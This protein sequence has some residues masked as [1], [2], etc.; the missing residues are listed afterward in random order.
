MSKLPLPTKILYGLGQL[1]ETTPA[2]Y[3]PTYIYLFYAPLHGPVLLSAYTVGVAMLL[4]TLTQAVANPFIGNWSDK[5]TSRLGR[6]R[7]FILTGSIPFGLVFFLIWSPFSHGIILAILLVFYLI[8]WDL[9]YVYVGVPYLALIPELTFESDDR[10]VLTTI[11]SYV[12]IF[13]IILAS[14]LPALLLTLRFGYTIVGAI[15]AVIA[16]A[17]FFLV[18][19]TIKEKPAGEIVPKNYSIIKS[20]VQTLKNKTFG[21]YIIAYV[22]FQFGFWFFLSSLGYVVQGVV[23][24]ANPNSE[25]F[26]GLFTL[27][28]VIFAIIFSP[29]LV[30]FSKSRGE[31]R[32]FILFNVI[33]GLSMILT[34]FIGYLHVISNV[35]QMA[36]IMIFAG[37]GLTS[38]FIL[39][40]AIISEI[41]DEDETMT[42][43][44]REGMYFGVQGLLERIPSGLSAYVLGWWITYLYIP[45]MN[46]IYIRS[47]GLIG[48]GFI[49]L[50]SFIFIIVPLKQG[51]KLKGHS[52]AGSSPLR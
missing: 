52:E 42:G 48:G 49:I 35:I 11:S 23:L 13:G 47:L 22:F 10:V 28:A 4:G 1:G 14:I 40:N 15:I 38:Y 39:P 17:A 24:P 51:I 30:R 5:S 3:L 34:F 25:T 7:F 32:A 46:P 8:G 31:K 6:R 44:R 19:L 16:A 45:T 9:F 43:Y 37:L 27:I 20:F 26:V 29:V 33:L 36:L 2:F 18:G 12:Q 41:I 21:R 50:T